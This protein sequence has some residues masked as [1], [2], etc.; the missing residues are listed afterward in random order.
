MLF[1]LLIIYYYFNLFVSVLLM[2]L[3]DWGFCLV[4]NWLF[5]FMWDVKLFFIIKFVFCFFNL[6][7]VKNG[8]LFLNFIV[9]FLLLVNEVILILFIR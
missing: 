6:D 7:W 4:I 8:I 9:F 3:F 1:I 5:F 2:F